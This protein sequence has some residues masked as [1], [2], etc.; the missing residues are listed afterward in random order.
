MSRSEVERKRVAER[1]RSAAG[2]TRQ[3]AALSPQD[4]GE[5]FARHR[6]GE[7][8]FR[9]AAEECLARDDDL[10]AA[11][12]SWG[13]FA[14]AVKAASALHGRELKAHFA[15]V[16]VAHALAEIIAETDPT[17]ADRVRHGLAAANTLHQHFYEQHLSRDLVCALAA[18][19]AA[20][21][22]V[23]ENR[24]WREAA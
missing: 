11:E 24:F 14:Q 21:L 4:A 7:A 19:V 9:A 23:I 12:K 17:A 13:A 1:I 5:R 2:N 10:Q 18:D 3:S 15:V 16:R 22:D 6:D 20:A 8:H